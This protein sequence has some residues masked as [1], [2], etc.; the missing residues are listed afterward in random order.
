MV[1]VELGL[2][3]SPDCCVP[4]AGWAEVAGVE[5]LLKLRPAP[6]VGDWNEPKAGVAEPPKDG[7]EVAAEV[8][9]PNAGA[10]CVGA[11]KDGAAGC[12]AVEVPKAG[13]WPVDAPNVGWE[14]APKLGVVVAPKLMP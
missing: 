7:A 5:V 14:V 1:G 11:P 3:L 6:V 10:A 8:W 12:W 13:D 9:A 2:K 4:K